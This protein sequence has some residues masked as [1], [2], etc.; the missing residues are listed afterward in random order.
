M[1]ILYLQLALLFVCGA[2]QAQTLQYS[3][4]AAGNR[5]SKTLVN[6]TSLYAKSPDGNADDPLLY[7]PSVQAHSFTTNGIIEVK[8]DGFDENK[9]YK[10]SVYT[11]GGIDVTSIIPDSELSTIDISS[12][13]RGVYIL[14]V[15]ID[16]ETQTFKISKK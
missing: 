6:V 11:I 9:K 14:S 13:Q 8:L 7:K 16:D 4:D 12:Q 1:K 15:T 2:M 10:I 5:I 3:Y